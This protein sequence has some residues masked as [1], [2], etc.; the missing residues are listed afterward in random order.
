[1]SS[2]INIFSNSSKDENPK[3][4]IPTNDDEAN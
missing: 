4:N 3:T 1:M 2:P